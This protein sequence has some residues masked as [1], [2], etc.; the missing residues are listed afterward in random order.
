M[1]KSEI[2]KFQLFLTLVLIMVIAVTYTSLIS[3][4]GAALATIVGSELIAVAIYI[5]GVAAWYTWLAGLV[6]QTSKK[7]VVAVS[8]FFSNLFSSTPVAA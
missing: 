2:S 4:V 3:F 6:V 1:Q 8:N 7:V 5:L